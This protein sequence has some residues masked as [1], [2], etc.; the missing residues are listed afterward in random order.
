MA[1]KKK[2]IKHKVVSSASALYGHFRSRVGFYISVLTIAG[3]IFGAPY[4]LDSHYAKASDL[5]NTDSRLEQKILEDKLNA[6]ENHVWSIQDHYKNIDKAP[7]DIKDELRDLQSKKD[8][9]KNRLDVL[10]KQIGVS[11]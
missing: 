6:I 9:V 7:Q 8:R 11:P 1:R 2:S 3:M 5:K 10:D 4:W